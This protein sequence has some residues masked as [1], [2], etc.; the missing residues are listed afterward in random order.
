MISTFVLQLVPDRIEALREALRVLAPTG[1]VA[2]LTWL[3]RDARQPFLPGEEFDEAVYDLEIDEPEGPD[4]PHA[5]DVVSG[6]TAT[7]ELRRA[8]FVKASARE[9]VSRVRVDD[10]V[11]PRL[12]ARLRRTGVDRKSDRGTAR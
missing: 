12:Q 5:G 6:R 9:E 11:V 10:G 3:D 1:M 8:G 4:E 7:N 2:Y